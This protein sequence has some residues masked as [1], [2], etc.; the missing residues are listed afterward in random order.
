VS[1]PFLI[2]HRSKSTPGKIY[3]RLAVVVKVGRKNV[4]FY[5]STGTGTPGKVAKNEWVPFNGISRQGGGWFIKVPGK[6]PTGELEQTA[7]WLKTHMRRK[8]P[9]KVFDEADYSDS[10]KQSADVNALIKQH[11][12]LYTP[13]GD[14]RGP[15]TGPFKIGTVNIGKLS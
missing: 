3:N 5:Q 10:A 11:K 7:S 1:K 2:R 15:P 12:A 13:K 6:I 4:A 9:T 8:K 14:G